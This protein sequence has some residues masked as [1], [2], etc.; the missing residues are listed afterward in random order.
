M[1][2]RSIDLASEKV[3]SLRRKSL[4][5]VS[6]IITAVALTLAIKAS[7]CS[8]I[9][10][11]QT[12]ASASQ[13]ASSEIAALTER[14]KSSDEEERR[15]AAL[16]LATLKT[17]AVAPALTAALNDPSERVRAVAATGL[18]AIN[19]PSLVSVLSARL[20][21]E[22]RPFVRKAIAYALGNFRS[23]QATP[24]LIA[25]LRDKDIEVR[26]AAAVALG[27]YADATAIEPL[28]NAL[29]DK[30][31]FVRAKAACALGVNSRAAA[32]AVPILI[33]LLTSDKEHEV[34]RQSA[35]ALGLIGEPSALPALERAVRD[36]DPY[37]SRAAIDAIKMIIGI[38]DRKV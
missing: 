25:A 10:F 35:I 14:L 7:G 3:E 5:T 13:D 28:T 18:G 9:A 17:P 33:K 12:Q 11:H 19:D 30:S 36:P 20:A 38:R 21:Q 4:V 15:D 8:A 27:Q 31:E 24:A 1:Q 23:A 29:R 34:K 26:G 16:A 32:R 37:L 2:R 22:K 6:L